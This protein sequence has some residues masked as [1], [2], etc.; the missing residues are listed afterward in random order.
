MSTE[1]SYRNFLIPN[2][3]SELG[4]E[5]SPSTIIDLE[6]MD[7]IDETLR[8]TT[9]PGSYRSHATDKEIEMY[10]DVLY[11]KISYGLSTLIRDHIRT[12][13]REKYERIQGL[14]PYKDI[15]WEALFQD[16]T[17]AWK[18]PADNIQTLTTWKD[19]EDIIQALDKFYQT[20]SK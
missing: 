3:P 15:S 16:T 20:N 2:Q 9:D 19:S 13:G 12:D 14:E 7:D 6:N 1:T 5:I 17:F 18:D 10:N 4:S 11:S 8:Q